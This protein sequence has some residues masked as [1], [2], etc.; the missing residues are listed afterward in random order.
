MACKSA[1]KKSKKAV[2]SPTVKEERNFSLWNIWVAST[3]LKI[4]LFVSYHSTDFDVHRNWLAITNKLPLSQW[5]LENTSQWTLDYPPFFAYFEWLLSQFVPNIVKED[6]CL[7]I[8]DKGVYSWPTIYFQRSTVIISEILYFVALQWYVNSSSPKDKSRSFVVASSLALSPGL[9]IVDHIHFQYNGMMFGILVFALVAAKLQK[10]CLCAFCFSTLLCFKHI[11]LY[12]APAFFVF[13]LRAYCLNWK[14]PRNI[15]DLVNFV[16]WQNLIKLGLIVI[17]VFSVAFGPFIYYGVLPSLL[18]RL[19][20]FSRGLTHAYWAPNIWAIYSFADRILLRLYSLPFFGSVISRFSPNLSHESIALKLSS[21]NL[22][23]T[24]GLVGEV[25]FLILPNIQPWVT[26]ALTLF[27]QTFSLLPL[28]ISPTFERFVGSI[29]L[30]GAAS[31]LFGW[32]VHEKAIMLVIVPFSFLVIQ[33]RRLVMP[34][35]LL[36]SAGYVSLFPLLYG[37]GEFM[38]KLL[39]TYVWCIIYFASF[40]EVTKISSSLSR[41]VFLLDRMSLIYIF[42]LIPMV[43]IVGVMDAVSHKFEILQKY[44]FVKLM[45]YSVYCAVGIISGYNG[46]CFLYYSDEKIWR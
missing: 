36:V 27:Y 22:S 21:S 33:D 4:L 30:C 7:D 26:F 3:L 13:L 9:F 24:K 2:D 29:T 11:F 18:Q 23:M 28:L 34:F 15:N 39:Y 5:Y 46:L 20:P 35:Q 10:Y 19:F 16:I 31:F 42:G 25:D 40:Q 32:H 8:V 38:F 17:G 12:I 37:P 14:I 6:G 43:F 41:R 44:E 1:L 45:I